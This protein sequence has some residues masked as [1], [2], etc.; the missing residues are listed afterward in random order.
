MEGSAEL[1]FP[2]GFDLA[3]QLEEAKPEIVVG[4]GSTLF[5]IAANE[6]ASRELL[7]LEWTAI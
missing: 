3:A 5:V 4:D 6:A 1:A 7:R 2:G